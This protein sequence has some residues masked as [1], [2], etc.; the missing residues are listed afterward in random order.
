MLAPRAAL[1]GAL[2]HAHP[3]AR[4]A[5]PLLRRRAALMVAQGV[6]SPA[7][8]LEDSFLAPKAPP[9]VDAEGRERTMVL[10]AARTAFITV[11][12]LKAITRHLHKPDSPFANYLTDGVCAEKWMPPTPEEPQIPT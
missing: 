11:D 6:S 3:T 10:A 12:H 8:G 1:L 9:Q 5:G 2:L 7:S 4:L